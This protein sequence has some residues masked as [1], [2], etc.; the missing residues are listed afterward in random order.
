MAVLRR[1]LG[2][3]HVVVLRTPGGL[4]DVGAA[5]DQG[6]ERLSVACVD[7]SDDSSRWCTSCMD[8]GRE[9]CIAA[10]RHGVVGTTASPSTPRRDDIW[11]IDRKIFDTGH[12]VGIRNFIVNRECLAQARFGSH[13][14]RFQGVNACRETQARSHGEG[15]EYNE[16]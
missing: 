16:F 10:I 7:A 1:I 4:G 5:R 15:R 8:A 2:G 3:A 12:C 13:P 14:G 9:P 6:L 11:S